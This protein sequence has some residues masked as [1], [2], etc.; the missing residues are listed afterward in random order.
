MSGDTD[1]V[2]DALRWQAWERA[3]GELRSMLKTFFGEPE[4]Y[5]K[6]DGLVEKFIEDFENE[7]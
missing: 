1:K 5:S 6:M 3:K 2:L 4:Q 7:Y